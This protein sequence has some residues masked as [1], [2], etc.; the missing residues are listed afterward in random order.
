MQANSTNIMVD[1]KKALSPEYGVELVS[2]L[3]GLRGVSRAWV[4]PRTSRILMVDYDPTI[5]DSRRILGTIVR[6]GFDAR[7]VGM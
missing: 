4:S 3:V 5:T 2:E 6:H 1:V 7:L